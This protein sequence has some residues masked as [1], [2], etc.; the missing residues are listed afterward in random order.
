V[1]NRETE[2]L[3]T[4]QETRGPSGRISMMSSVAYTLHNLFP[5]PAQAEWELSPNRREL[6][7]RLSKTQARRG[8]STVLVEGETC[9]GK[10]L[11]AMNQEFERR[12]QE[13][14]NQL[15][16][17]NTGLAK[18]NEELARESRMK[19]DLLARMSHEFRTPLNAI[20]GFSDL[21]AEQGEGSLG[22]AYADYVRHVSDGAQHLLA[23]VN[24][25]L[26]LS[27]IEAGR[28]ELRCRNFSV[29]EAT[30]EVLSVIEP[31]AKAK[32][33]EL[34][35]D[36]PCALITYGDRTRF[37]QILFN[38]LS[39]AVKF[40]PADGSVQVNAERDCDGIR[41][42]VIDTGIG[43]QNEKQTDI[44]EEF[45]QVTSPANGVKEGAGLGLT[46]TKGIVELHGGRIWVE[47]ASGEGS[48]F[49]F[50]IPATPAGD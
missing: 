31:L 26:D 38:L 36:V 39:N 44:F 50:T 4:A 34:H 45:V 8:S 7:N 5:V 46:I 35:N 14:T 3:V 33:I 16:E 28:A 32:N 2:G 12:V 19:S 40:T 17:A 37:K 48:R 1:Q 24:D 42:C 25:I 49:Y 11:I 27:R 29:P 22:D 10:E 13:R 9:I 43:I 15:G 20:V 21:L 6:K 41:F 47:S 18:Q 30:A 23:L